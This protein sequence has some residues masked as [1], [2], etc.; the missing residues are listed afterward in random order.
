MPFFLAMGPSSCTRLSITDYTG[1]H[2]LLFAACEETIIR[3]HPSNPSA[4]P[5]YP[6][7][8]RNRR[9]CRLRPAHAAPRTPRRF[10]RTEADSISNRLHPGA[11][12]GVWN[13]V[14]PR[15]GS[16]NYARGRSGRNRQG[17]TKGLWVCPPLEHND[18]PPVRACKARYRFTCARSTRS[19]SS[20][21]RM[22]A[23][24]AGPSSTT[25]A[26]SHANG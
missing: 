20:Q 8:P 23:S 26:P 6:C 15:P 4:R 3:P 13:G 19:H 1:P 24:S 5:G 7:Q 9:T 10:V 2:A 11:C 22:S 14:L 21:P 18:H 17:A 16:G 25:T 12:T